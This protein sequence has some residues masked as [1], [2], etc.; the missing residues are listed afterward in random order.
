MQKLVKKLYKCRPMPDEAGMAL[1]LY[2]IGGSW[3]AIGKDADRLYL[4]LGW[5]LTD[6]AEGDTIYSYILVSTRG[7]K[8]LQKLGI[9]YQIIKV[10]VLQD[11]DVESLATIQQAL[12]YLRLQADFHSFTYPFI[13]HSTMIEDIGY[14]REVRLTSI[15]ISRESASLRID[16][17]EQIE[18]VNGHEWN[19]SHIGVMLLSYISDIITEQ[20]AYL[21]AYIQAPKQTIKI[22]KLQNADLYKRYLKVRVQTPADSLALVKV[23]N[24]FLTFDDDAITAASLNHDVLLYEWN[25]IGHRGRIVALIEASLYQAIQ[26]NTAVSVIDS[27]FTYPLYRL[28]LKES[29]LNHKYDNQ[30]IYTNVAIRKCRAGNY[31]I[32]ASHH[33][34]P[35]PE[36][37]IPS[38]LGAY[39][40]NLLD[41]KE[42]NAMLIS[43][44]HQ[45]YDKNITP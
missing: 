39:A 1:V 29:F 26:K 20:F 38:T 18:L 42:R 22:Q 35:L 37:S 44:A 8:V 36:F 28:G 40:L 3:V 17:S 31:V 14:I 16:N 10:S 5:E 24:T 23:Q 32:T 11:I 13:C 9:K 30:I 43:L 12:D 45:T 4:S 41:S 7:I 33:G 6:F 2:D 15:T 34:T 25:V 19:F 21:L 27:H